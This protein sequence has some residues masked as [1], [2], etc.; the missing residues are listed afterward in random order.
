MGH[1][2]LLKSKP[3]IECIIARNHNDIRV[4]CPNDT[5]TGCLLPAETREVDPDPTASSAS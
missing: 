3:A 5:I 4:E 2:V 1:A